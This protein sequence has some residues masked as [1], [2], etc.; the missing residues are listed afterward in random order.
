[1]VRD[2]CYDRILIVLHLGETL[3][4]VGQGGL[5]RMIA[6]FQEYTNMPIL[7]TNSI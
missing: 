1:M 3:L 6:V 4:V 2:L 5:Q 7:L